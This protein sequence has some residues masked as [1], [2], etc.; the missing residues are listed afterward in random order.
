MKKLLKSIV[1]AG[2]SFS[3]G[4][5]MA[6]KVNAENDDQLIEKPFEEYSSIDYVKSGKAEDCQYSFVD[7]SERFNDRDSDGNV[8]GSGFMDEKYVNETENR[9][10]F[11]IDQIVDH[12][13]VKPENEERKGSLSAVFNHVD[14][15][16][17]WYTKVPGED[18]ERIEGATTYT[19]GITVPA[20]ESERWYILRHTY[21][22]LRVYTNICKVKASHDFD[23]V[24]L[25][26]YDDGTCS[27]KL[28]KTK[29][30][31]GVVY[32][33]D[34]FGK[35]TKF[36]DYVNADENFLPWAVKDAAGELIETDFIDGSKNF[37]TIK[38]SA[39]YSSE[40]Y[41]A[42]E[43][44]AMKST[45]G[46]KWYIPSR[47][48]L[49]QICWNKN[50]IDVGMAEINKGYYPKFLT[51]SGSYWSS[52]QSLNQDEPNKA[53]SVFMGIG[54]AQSLV[55]KSVKLGVRAV[56]KF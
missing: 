30:L 56:G 46:R 5:T 44:V 2:I 27:T 32:D 24:G 11:L 12:I 19:Y 37:E 33:V 23:S 4:C 35:P 51:A 52:S 38:K 3:L 54:N 55:T 8:I 21:Y 17:Q 9:E 53:W 39:S 18:W 43:K 16:Y 22:D 26:A 7:S 14:G 34:Q 10:L 1:F 40:K 31:L 13:Y 50:A 45:G 20:G 49:Y 48:E 6:C 28:T 47:D 29:V 41:P 15:E 42:F 36:V 25:L